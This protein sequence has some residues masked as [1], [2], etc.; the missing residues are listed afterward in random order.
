MPQRSEICTARVPAGS[1][2][3]ALVSLFI[4]AV[5][6]TAP[7]VRAETTASLIDLLDD[8]SPDIRLDA[9]DALAERRAGR[10]V[11]P[12]LAILA[13]DSA[14]PMDRMQ[15]AWALGRIGD[16]RT[17]VPLIAALETDFRERR[18]YM[19]AIIPALGLLG[20]ARAVPLLLDALGNRDDHWL[21]RAA[22]AE[23][24]GRIGARRAVPDLVNAAWMAD[25]RDAAIV[26][27]ARIADTGGAVPAG[28]G[29]EA[30]IE[31]LL[32]ALSDDEEPETREAAIAGLVATGD[33]AAEF[34][35]LRVTPAFAGLP[36]IASRLRVVAILGE[37]GG[38]RSLR[39]LKDVVAGNDP[40]LA[41]AARAALKSATQ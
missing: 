13:A 14:D 25:T 9:I 23:A 29:G 38:A 8:P 19:M 6:V 32:S 26:A 10:A 22:A 37:I 16:S 41:N 36:D 12:L 34:I 4:A 35:A 27:L 21:A 30:V 3:V 7:P 2:L 28:A 17:V 20:D 15:A 24:L 5:L 18:G 39:M 31:T 1:W 11:A 40:A 33:D